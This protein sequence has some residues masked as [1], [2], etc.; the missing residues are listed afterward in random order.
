MV[1]SERKTSAYLDNILKDT[2]ITAGTGSQGESVLF[3]VTLLRY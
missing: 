2:Q 3:C 1:S